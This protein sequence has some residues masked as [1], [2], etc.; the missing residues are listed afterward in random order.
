[1]FKK[2]TKA[3]FG[4]SLRMKFFLM[5]LFL[6]VAAIAVS[7]FT[8]INL[9]DKNI[10]K[11]AQ[12]EQ[13]ITYEY[14]NKVIENYLVDLNRR[15]SFIGGFEKT[16]VSQSPQV[17]DA[18]AGALKKN[19]DLVAI[20]TVL[21]DG[22]ISNSALIDD[23]AVPNNPQ[24]LEKD[25]SARAL[26]GGEGVRLSKIQQAGNRQVIKLMYPLQN[27]SGFLCMVFDVKAINDEMFKITKTSGHEI[28]LID[29]EGVIMLS[30]RP[31]GI[32]KSIRGF[33]KNKP[34]YGKVVNFDGGD[35]EVFVSRT[36]IDDYYVAVFQ[37]GGELDYTVTL[38]KSIV[39]V[40]ILIIL[41]LSYL[42]SVLLSGYI[43]TP[44]LNLDAGIKSVT[45]GNLNYRISVR[46]NNEIGILTDSFNHMV[47]NLKPM[48]AKY[49]E[50]EAVE[51]KAVLANRIGHEIV[52]PVMSVNMAVSL[53]QRN[54]DKAGPQDILKYAE[55][56]KKEMQQIDK[57][58]S[59]LLA[60]SNDRQPVMSDFNLKEA[61][62]EAFSVVQPHHNILVKNDIN[63]ALLMYGNSSEI[64][65]LFINLF[66]NSIDALKE[67][68]GEI[69]VSVDGSEG[70]M[71]IVFSDNGCG[72][73][74][75]NIIK[76]FDPLFTTKMQG[77]GLGLAVVRKITE[78]HG[79]RIDVESRVNAGTKFIFSF[80]NIKSMG[81]KS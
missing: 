9:S 78:R 6:S 28:S 80:K 45:E 22:T 81:V 47:E 51:A 14:I 37:S 34:G 10:R 35:A 8:L 21:P 48:I 71:Q 58:S 68:G 55:I 26:S 49:S 29:G 39:I 42:L 79:G 57:I 11:H 15:L 2:M 27:K 41:G 12:K 31:E 23:F 3:L 40:W 62:S 76:I 60:F 75:T 44:M 54:K 43:L 63:S 56:I 16:G 36:A 67:T 53:L 25:C 65:L 52:D 24:E 74:E 50:R 46:D 61:V 17:K 38:M 5:F 72:I 20:F 70:K 64:K 33:G 19:N 59:N 18:I 1:M 4:L 7:S 66:E 32:G 73:S 69:K 13:Q 30:S 77:L